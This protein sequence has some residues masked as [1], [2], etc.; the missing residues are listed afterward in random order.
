[1]KRS[2]SALLVTKNCY[3]MFSAISVILRWTVLVD[4]GT[5]GVALLALSPTITFA[6]TLAAG[7]ISASPFTSV[8]PIHCKLVEHHTV[9]DGQAASPVKKG[10]KHDQ[11]LNFLLSYLFDLCRPGKLCIKG[12]PKILCCF[13]S[14]YWFSKKLDWSGS[15]V[16]AWTKGTAVLFETCIEILQSRSKRSSLPW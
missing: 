9:S 13:D 8:A 3:F 7:F 12:H 6:I 15:L 16:A 4:S 5:Q 1:M 10:A 2:V 14:F 11:S